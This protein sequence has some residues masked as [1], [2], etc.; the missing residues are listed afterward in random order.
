MSQKKKHSEMFS[1]GRLYFEGH[2]KGRERNLAPADVHEDFIIYLNK[3]EQA[4]V[5]VQQ[6]K[7]VK[8]DTTLRR[9]NLLF[10]SPQMS[11]GAGRAG[12]LGCAFGGPVLRK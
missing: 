11:H 9:C 12:G 4:G 2:F 3:E 5:R 10:Q 1:L 7:E 6:G 8:F